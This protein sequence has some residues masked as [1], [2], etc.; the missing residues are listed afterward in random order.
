MDTS[1]RGDEDYL[2]GKG[3][4]NQE[5]VENGRIFGNGIMNMKNAFVSYIAGVDAMHQ[6]E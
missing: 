6:E 4:K 3:W 5:T 2:I 1:V